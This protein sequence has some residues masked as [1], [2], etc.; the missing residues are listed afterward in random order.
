MLRLGKEREVLNVI[1]DRI[2]T[3]TYAADLAKAILT[4]I[5]KLENE[6]VELY[7][8]SNEGVCSWFDFAKAIFENNKI[9]C[10]VYP[11]TTDQYPTAAKRP[12][13][14][15]LNKNKLK[16]TFNISIPYWKESLKACL[17]KI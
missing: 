10:N 16:E 9:N 2:G 14:S 7:H 11:I 13:F 8:F 4:I 5:P 17:A 3:P 6:N 12:H 15:L 1:N